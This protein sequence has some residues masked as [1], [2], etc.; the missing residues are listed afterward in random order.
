MSQSPKDDGPKGKV[1]GSA[2][3]RPADSTKTSPT[4]AGAV[5]AGVG[6]GADA[7]GG[8]ASD[9][10]GGPVTDA[11]AEATR[12]REQ[13]LRT[14]ADFDNFRKRARREVEDA[15]RKGAEELLRTL[16]PVFDNLERAVLH[17]EQAADAKAIADGVRMVLRQFGDTLD[18]VGIKRILTV[19]L[20]FDPLVHEAIQQVETAEHPPGTVIAE[21]APGYK[22]G[23]RLVRAALVVVAKPPSTRSKPPG[24]GGG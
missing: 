13:L 9:P 20:P 19:G 2:S 15:H 5:E 11:R 10:E 14:A 22:Y 12:L 4:D 23:D 24:D 6:A 18:R 7:N 21:V 17:A 3:T 16:L 8:V 1:E